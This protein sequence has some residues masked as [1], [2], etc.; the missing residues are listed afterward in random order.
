MTKTGRVTS[1]YQIPK[2]I[3]LAEWQDWQ[4]QLRNSAKN[5]E[6]LEKFFMEV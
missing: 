1:N 5:I 3:D 4:W 2:D 6:D